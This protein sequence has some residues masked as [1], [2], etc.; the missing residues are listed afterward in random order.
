MNNIQ[1]ALDAI[2]A[3]DRAAN[4]RVEVTAK[5][6]QDAG[7]SPVVICDGVDPVLLSINPATEKIYFIDDFLDHTDN[8]ISWALGLS[9][10]RAG[11]S[12]SLWDDPSYKGALLALLIMGRGLNSLGLILE[13]PIYDTNPHTH[14]H[15]R[16]LDNHKKEH[17]KIKV[18]ANNI[19]QIDIPI[20]IQIIVLQTFLKARHSLEEWN[21]DWLGY[22]I[23]SQQ[24]NALPK[25]LMIETLPAK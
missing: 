9:E 24:Y 16:V 3:S 12:K 1:W 18:I 11:N 14:F 19:I 22:E 15:Q 6:L 5:L 13:I 4:G 20:N 21:L 17:G 7:Q 2:S 8:K 23:H 25:E 10:V